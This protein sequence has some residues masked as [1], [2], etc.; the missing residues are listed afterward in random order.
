MDSQIIVNS[1]VNYGTIIYW[2]IL[3]AAFVL[4]QQ[5]TGW[6]M[7]SNKF[8]SF[9]TFFTVAVIVGL[10]LSVGNIYWKRP[11]SVSSH[12]PENYKL[13]Q[14]RNHKYINETLPLDGYDYK[15]CD[16]ANVTFIWNGTAPFL[17][18]DNKVNGECVVNSNNSII[19]IT[20]GLSKKFNLKDDYLALLEKTGYKPLPD[21]A[22]NTFSP[23]TDQSN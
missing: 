20:W 17:L 18:E 21:F 9:N 14:V 3:C 8:F 22:T 16:F 13:T 10:V 11:I 15:Y 7:L 2:I 12:F 6:P 5:K 4:K 23:V 1:I 19:L